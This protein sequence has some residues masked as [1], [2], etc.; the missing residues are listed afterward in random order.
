MGQRRRGLRA[1]RAGG[2]AAR[3]P[4]RAGGRARGGSR[5]AALPGRGRW[6]WTYAGSQSQA[7]HPRGP[8]RAERKQRTPWGR[9]RATGARRVTCSSCQVNAGS[10]K[11]RRGRGPGTAVWSATTPWAAADDRTSNV[12]VG[13]M[14]N[15]AS[16]Y[17]ADWLVLKY[18]P[19]GRAALVGHARRRVRQLRLPERRRLRPRRQ[20]LRVRR[21]ARCQGQPLLHRRQVPRLRRQGALEAGRA[22]P[23][24]RLAR[25][26]GDGRRRG[27]ERQRLRHRDQ[28]RRDPHRP[29]LPDHEADAGRGRQVAQG[30]RLADLRPLRLLPLGRR[31]QHVRLVLRRRVRRF[32]P[33]HGRQVHDRRASL[34][35][36][37]PGVRR[38]DRGAIRWRWPRTRPGSSSR[39]RPSGRRP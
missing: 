5:C 12:A 29:A 17:A 14:T 4:G 39:A 28:L 37:D 18:S 27:R 30:D 8:R 21:P 16:T 3:A 23:E 9:P 36:Q 6:T 13:G 1:A 15:T 20:R 10:G 24:R 25:R 34:L 11:D 33:A 38:R 2:G 32:V 26:P 35:A 7:Q 19:S 31:Q 22:G